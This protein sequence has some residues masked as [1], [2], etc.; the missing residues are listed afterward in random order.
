MKTEELNILKGKVETMNK[1]LREL[2]EEEL[3]NVVGGNFG[4]IFYD[5]C[6]YSPSRFENAFDPVV[7]SRT[8]ECA[9]CVYN[10]NRF[11]EYSTCTYEE[12]HKG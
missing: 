2:S 7:W 5:N 8:A 4:I 10:S 1:N 3:V 11:W 6:H 12:K 9:R